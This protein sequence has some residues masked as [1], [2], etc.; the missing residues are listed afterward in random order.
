MSEEKET[1]KSER[2]AKGQFTKG[3]K[4]TG[5]RKLGTGNRNGNVRDRLKEQVEPF[6]EKISELLARVQKEEGT[7]EML[8][9]VEKFMPYFMPKYS[10]VALSADMDRPISE[11]QRLVELNDMYTKKELSINFKQMTV[12]DKNAAKM[13][14]DND[15]DYDPDFDVEEFLKKRVKE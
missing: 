15:P 13:A 12:V 9:L 14:G 6:V 11:E 1:K 4:K 3:H 8:T 10:A 5:G 2:N 7:K